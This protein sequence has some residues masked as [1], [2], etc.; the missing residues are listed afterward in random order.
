MLLEQDEAS[1]AWPGLLNYLPMFRIIIMKT[2]IGEVT[3]I[4]SKN[5]KTM[6]SLLYHEIQKRAYDVVGNVPNRKS[7]SLAETPMNV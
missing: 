1:Y 2:Y 7:S 6:E 4:R 3:Q 5:K